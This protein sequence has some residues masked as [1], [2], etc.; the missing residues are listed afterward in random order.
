MQKADHRL[1]CPALEI[2]WVTSFNTRN[3]RTSFTCQQV[4]QGFQ[5]SLYIPSFKI[6]F[7]TLFFLSTYLKE[8]LNMQSF[9]ISKPLHKHV[10]ETWLLIHYYYHGIGNTEQPEKHRILHCSPTSKA[11]EKQFKFSCSLPVEIFEKSILN[12]ISKL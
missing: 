3:N 9:F 12:T 7:K 1:W 8:N 6:S 2:I 11:V 5:F 10:H 4:F